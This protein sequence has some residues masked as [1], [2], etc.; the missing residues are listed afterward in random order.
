MSTVYGTL[1]SCF[2]LTGIILDGFGDFVLGPKIENLRRFVVTWK[3]GTWA[4]LLFGFSIYRFRVHF[5]SPCRSADVIWIRASIP[6]S[7]GFIIT[8]PSGL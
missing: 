2:S 8:A 3:K 4:G 7:R 5:Y 1:D 6:F